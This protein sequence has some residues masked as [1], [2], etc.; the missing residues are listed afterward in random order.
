MGWFDFLRAKPGRVPTQVPSPDRPRVLEL[1]KYDTCAYC[2]RVMRAVARLGVDVT[3]RDVRVDPT[4]REVLRDRTGRSQVPC[5]FVDGE[6]LFESADI[7]A[8]LEAYAA[9]RVAG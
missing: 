6:P 8:W 9:A 7:V 4:N 5:L 3:I 1:Y 2:V